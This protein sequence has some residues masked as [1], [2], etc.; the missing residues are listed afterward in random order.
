MLAR[1]IAS[2]ALLWLEKVLT[3]PAVSGPFK[4]GWETVANKEHFRGPKIQTDTSLAL[5]S[6]FAPSIFACSLASLICFSGCSVQKQWSAMGGSRADG[7]VDLSYEYGGLQQPQI[8]EAQGVDLAATTCGGWGYTSSQPF[9]GTMSRC[10]AVN[11]YGM[12]L[13]YLVTAQVSVLGCSRV[14]SCS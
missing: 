12:C 7:T 2:I 14:F 10:E 4:A 9:G 5:K 11:G 1:T 13:R 6:N 8:D 3:K